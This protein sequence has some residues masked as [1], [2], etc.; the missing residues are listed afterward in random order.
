MAQMPTTTTP[1]SQLEA[2]AWEERDWEDLI[3][4][5]IAGSVIP[6]IGSELLIVEV[7]GRW[8]PLYR[9][10]AERLAQRLRLSSAPLGETRS[11]NDVICEYLQADRARNTADRVYARV[12]EVF[13]ELAPSPPPALQ[14]IAD[15]S[16]FKL[17]LTTAADSLLETAINHARFKG[18]NGT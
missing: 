13:Q 1:P 11:I 14:Q 2:D 5:V 15:I 18:I 12:C 7:D 10:V 6:V 17:F 3:D 9:V 8:H 16:D 4:D